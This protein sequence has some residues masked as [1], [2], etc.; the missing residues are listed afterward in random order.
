MMSYCPN[1]GAAYEGTPKF[2][3]NCGAALARPVQ[4]AEPVVGPSSDA[5][6]QPKAT[7]ASPASP[8]PIQ[9]DATPV[10]PGPS[11]YEPAASAGQG[12][13]GAM[14]GS[15]APS[16]VP[17]SYG[18]SQQP[19]GVGQ[20]DYS[21]A[22][23]DQN[24]YNGQKTSQGLLGFAWNDVKNSE[25]LVPRTALLGLIGCVP[26]L[27]FVASGYCLRWGRRAAF[28]TGD[29]MPKDLFGDK[30]FLIGFFAFVVELVFGIVMGL[31]SCIPLVGV[32]AALALC[33]PMMLACMHVAMTDELGAGFR[34]SDLWEK[35]KADFGGLLAIVFVPGLIA[36][37][38]CM[39]IMFVVSL[40]GGVSLFGL[41]YSIDAGSAVLGGAS[42][43]G[44]LIMLLGVYVCVVVSLVANLVSYR[45]LGYWAGRFAPDWV[46]ESVRQG[47]SPL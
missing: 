36:A 40:V 29:P 18:T 13:G 23:Y 45:A 21:R 26:V 44:M 41:A 42:V 14:G 8:E 9:L 24:P 15:P 38:A 30:A 27:N 31:L 37:L 17:P 43:F 11:A 5:P 46:Q 32:I 33:P 1:C 16:Y 3:V 6:L 39:V 47:V 28:R 7:P 22:S 34:V 35:T 2:C 20:Q 25:G 4:P 19:S 12:A 10:E